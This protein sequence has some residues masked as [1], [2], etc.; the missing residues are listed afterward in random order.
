MLSLLTRK[1]YRLSRQPVI[2][3]LRT[4][5]GSDG[6][7][8]KCAV[9]FSGDKFEPYHTDHNIS[10]SYLRNTNKVP[11]SCPEYTHLRHINHRSVPIRGSIIFKYLFAILSFVYLSVCHV[12]D[13]VCLTS[14]ANLS[15]ITTL[16]PIW[17]KTLHVTHHNFLMETFPHIFVFI[18]WMWFIKSIKFAKRPLECY[19]LPFRCTFESWNCARRYLYFLKAPYHYLLANVW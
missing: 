6:W 16:S 3:S 5:D 1:I 9:V 18:S 12:V 14:Y 19:C 7:G 4:C 13:Y 11:V 15:K 2:L 10:Y 8:D 17:Y